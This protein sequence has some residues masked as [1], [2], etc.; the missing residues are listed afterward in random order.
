[1]STG[2]SGHV[3]GKLWDLVWLC[4]F[5]EI[6]VHTVSMVSHELNREYEHG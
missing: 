5:S 2:V 1:M 6:R 4:F 3:A